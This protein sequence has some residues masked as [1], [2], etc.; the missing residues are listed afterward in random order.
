MSEKE[1]SSYGFVE[2]EMFELNQYQRFQKVE[3]NDV[4]LDLGCSK[5]FF[6]FLN[7]HLNINYIGLDASIDCVKD[8]YDY[9][10]ED[11]DPF[12]INS[13]L[14]DKFHV[15]KFQSI[16]HDLPAKDVNSL[17]FKS[18]V[19][20]INKKINFLKFDIEGYERLFL[21]DE[22]DLFKRSVD[23]FAGEVHFTETS[24]LGRADGY[25][26]LNKMKEDDDIDFKLYSIDMVDITDYFWSHKDFY[27]EIIINGLID[28]KI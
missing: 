8:F 9:L 5:G 13:F 17:T 6:Y 27:T 26:V 16:F 21:K 4:V 22:Y 2:N 1:L 10:Q 12:I 20:I 15:E 18:L 11:D 23:K 25:E 7:R 14:S 3:E 24:A 28:S 19:K